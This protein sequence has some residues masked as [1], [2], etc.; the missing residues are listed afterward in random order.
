VNTKQETAIPRTLHLS[1]WSEN[2]ALQAA[3]Q[4]AEL[5]QHPGFE[6]LC[7]ALV[8]REQQILYTQLVNARPLESAAEYEGKLGEVRGLRAFKGIA[9]GIIEH[10]KTV[11]RQQREAEEVAT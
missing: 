1:G 10:G 3:R 5:M 8:S 4:V 7:E 9:Q 11:E 6:D 2:R